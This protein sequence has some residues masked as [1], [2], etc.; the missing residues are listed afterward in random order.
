MYAAKL[1]LTMGFVANLKSLHVHSQSFGNALK[2]QLGQAGSISPR[3]VSYEEK[4]TQM[5]IEL[6]EGKSQFPRITS[7]KWKTLFGYSEK[8]AIS[9]KKMK[10]ASMAKPK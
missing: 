8:R 4:A 2:Q 6:E 3:I 10:L 5:A 1:L 9:F 7:I